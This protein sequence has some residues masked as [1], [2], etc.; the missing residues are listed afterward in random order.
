MTWTAPDRTRSKPPLIADER[1]MLQAWLDFH[2]DTL[3]RKCAGLDAKQLGE[4][5]VPPSAMSLHGLVRHLSEVER[6]WFRVA[7]AGIDLDYVYSRADNPNS[8]FDNT[9]QSDPATDLAQ[10]LKEVELADA[11][12]AD[13]SLEHTF[14][15]PRRP[16]LTYNLRWVYTHMIEEYARH[17]G[18]ADLLRERIDGATG[19]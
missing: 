13:L 12:V 7:A 8:D 17:N 11:A 16:E 18:H 9:E 6:G 10:Y 3:L 15:H 2:R 19:D 14:A 5:P 4:R 1:P